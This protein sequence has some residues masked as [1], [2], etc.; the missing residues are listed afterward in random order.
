MTLQELVYRSRSYRRFEDRPVAREVLRELVDLARMSPSGANMQPLKYLLAHTQ[1]KRDLVF[2]CLSWAGYLS[3][4]PGPADGERPGGYI[5]ILG[6]TT[7]SKSFGVDHGIAAQTICLG[8][9]EQGIGTC[10]IGSIHRERLRRSLN[11]DDTH[12]IL[13]VIAL[14]YPG[15]TVV[16]EAMEASGDVRYWRDSADVHHVPKRNLEDVLLD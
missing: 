8:A 10:I 1:E 16:A 13:L 6:D 4:W 5:V 14:G 9:A 12:E 15:E 7:V 3:D 2:P 11:L